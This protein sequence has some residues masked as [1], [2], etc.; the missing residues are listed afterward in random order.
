MIKGCKFEGVNKILWENN[1]LLETE[2]IGRAASR[3]VHFNVATGQTIISSKGQKR[4][5]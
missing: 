5:L 2:D 4:E 1:I 3:T